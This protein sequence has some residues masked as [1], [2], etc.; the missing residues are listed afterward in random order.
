MVRWTRSRIGGGCRDRGR[1]A[2]AK[3]QRV[4]ADIGAEQIPDRYLSPRTLKF[5]LDVLA[6]LPPGILRNILGSLV[7]LSCF[8]LARRFIRAGLPA[9][10][11]WLSGLLG[12]GADWLSGLLGLCAD[13]LSGLLGLCADR[14]SGLLGLSILVLTYFMPGWGLNCFGGLLDLACVAFYAVGAYSYV[15]LAQNFAIGSRG[16]LA[17]C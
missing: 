6:E 17:P 5:R 12:L 16:L 4:C 8:G 10:T 1:H 15:L 14:F 11:D 7:R 3:R 9:A 13:W 2:L